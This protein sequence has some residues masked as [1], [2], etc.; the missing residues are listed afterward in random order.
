MLESE[1]QHLFMS[2]HK[3][4]SSSHQQISYDEHT[5]QSATDTNEHMSTCMQMSRPHTYSDSYVTHRPLTHTLFV[6]PRRA[7]VL[8]LTPDGGRRSIYLCTYAYKLSDVLVL[9]AHGEVIAVLQCRCKTFV[10]RGIC[11]ALR[12]NSQSRV[13]ACFRGKLEIGPV[14]QECC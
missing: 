4:D 8:S 1:L 7:C 11:S 6:S 3:T 12:L 14:C 5:H 2:P 10:S 13:S 9:I